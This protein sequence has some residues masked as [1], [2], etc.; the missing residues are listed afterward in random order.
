MGTVVR[1]VP[2]NDRPVML[3]SAPIKAVLAATS[4]QSADIEQ[5]LPPILMQGVAKLIQGTGLETTRVDVEQIPLPTALIDLVG[6]DQT[7]A[8]QTERAPT[9]IK[10]LE[11]ARAKAF[12]QGYADGETEGRRIWSE[13]NERLA[14]LIGQ[15]EERWK[16]R[17]DE[18]EDLAV[19]IAFAALTRVLGTTL[20]SREG[21]VETV[22]SVLS[23]AKEDRAQLSIRLSPQ[24]FEF[25]GEEGRALLTTGRTAVNC[26]ADSRIKLGGC[27]LET[28]HGTLDGRLEIQLER[29]KEALLDAR[30]N[31]A[32]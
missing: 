12:D 1:Q 25:L 24:D 11:A 7:P 17:V 22:R 32:S 27:L 5:P 3:P 21:V 16:A 9:D 13:D 30:R 8:F 15:I 2:R 28:E 18:A 10:E 23:E 4:P 14:A 26:V 20:T 19:E 31:S 29:L 6:A